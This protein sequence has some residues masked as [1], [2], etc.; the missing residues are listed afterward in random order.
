MPSDTAHTLA[1]KFHLIIMA[2]LTHKLPVAL[3]CLFLFA[4]FLQSQNSM[5]GAFAMYGDGKS[6]HN[7]SLKAIDS[8]VI[9]TSLM[10]VRYKASY[11]M[12]PEGTPT[13][14]IAV[15]D[16]GTSHSLFYDFSMH[17]R[18]RYSYIQLM[19]S[20][21]L[22]P[23]HD[24]E[25]EELM[26][27]R[28]EQM[29]PYGDLGG[30]GSFFY[31]SVMYD[32]RTRVFKVVIPDIWAP[33]KAGS[34]YNL[35]HIYEEDAPKLEWEITG[36]HCAVASFECQKAE[37]D[38]RGRRW[39]AWFTTEIP[40]SEGPWKL[41]GLPGLILM[42]RD[43]TGQYSFEAVSV[44]DKPEPFYDYV[45]EHEN[46]TAYRKFKRYERNCFRW[47]KSFNEGTAV[48]IITVNGIEE[49]DYQNWRMP[50]YPMEWP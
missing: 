13:W 5:H 38:F 27:E 14:H 37:C 34:T 12:Y 8:V 9:D 30:I 25:M 48:Y 31:R 21:S 10:T 15:L 7:N 41:K 36:E 46:R 45:Y 18:N 22:G 17:I 4:P 28:A 44:T 26:K 19:K 6:P 11:C 16:V 1:F 24:V 32:F 40:V 2:I 33:S 20:D 47:P 3:I 35:A 23:G 39:E 29:A 49:A 43:T 42:A 50:Y